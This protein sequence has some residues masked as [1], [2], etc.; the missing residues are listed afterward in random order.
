M[1][2]PGRYEWFDQDGVPDFTVWLTTGRIITIE[3]KN[4]RSGDG[5][6]RVETQKT[7]ASKGDPMSRFYRADQFDV[8]AACLYNRTGRWEYLFA[9]TAELR[10]SRADERY[11]EPL[12][13]IPWPVTAPWHERLVDTLS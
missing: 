1:V 12:Q 5:A 13:P 2:R 3:V 10:R 8:L 11:L 7:R 4:V 6:L 9:R